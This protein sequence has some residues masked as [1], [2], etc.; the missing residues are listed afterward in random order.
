M[1]AAPAA[2]AASIEVSAFDEKGRV[3]DTRA[4]LKHISPKAWEK[5]GIPFSRSGLLVTD[6]QGRTVRGRHWWVA[7]STRP[8]W[9]WRD[10]SNV[11]F[12]FPWPIP[13]D[14]FST[15]LIDGGGNGYIDGQSI[16]LNEEIAKTAYRSLQESLKERESD[17]DPVYKPSSEAAA[18]LERARAAM[19]EARGAKIPRDRAEL[20]DKAL[21]QISFAWQQVLFEHGEQTVRHPKAGKRLRW[22][23]TLDETLIDHPQ[24]F[25]WTAA[26][27]QES[28]ADWVRLVFKLNPDDFTYSRKNSFPQY[29]ALIQALR[30]RKINIMGSVLDSMLWAKGITPELYQK[31]TNNLAFHFKDHI[32]SWEVASEPNGNWLGGTSDPVPDETILLCVQ[33]GMLEVKRIDPSFETVATL[34]WWEGTAPDDRHGLF[35]WLRWA[36][37]RG[38]GRGMDVIALSI[39][40]HRHPMGLAFDRV[41]RELHELFPRHSLMLG[42]WSFGDEEE[43]QGYWWLKPRGTREPRKD[44]T[45]LFA[46]SAPAIPNSLGGGFYWPTLEHMIRPEKKKTSA[47]FRVYQRALKRVRTGRK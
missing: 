30:E 24:R 43:L 15:V 4:L 39:Y 5:T 13:K 17:W 1:L 6:L 29:D 19:G 37:P 18:L 46:G 36:M 42:G 7:R 33:K 8:A 28:G 31:R 16:L 3:L 20:F 26:K 9:A 25:A 34:H 27:I 11:R 2:R 21:T 14:G 40:P 44:L 38:F 45:V 22:G 41:F 32:R 47:L 12:S 35:E 23:L 10:A